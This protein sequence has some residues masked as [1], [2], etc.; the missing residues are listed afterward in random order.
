MEAKYQLET[1]MV[2]NNRPL[3]MIEVFSQIHK[4]CHFYSDPYIMQ[5]VRGAGEL[6]DWPHP[7]WSFR[8]IPESC[9]EFE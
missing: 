6:V 9:R 3:G 5:S 8:S 7:L 1:L 4:V 2:S